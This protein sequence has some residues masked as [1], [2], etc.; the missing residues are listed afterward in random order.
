MN[1]T[2]QITNKVR[3][4][5]GNYPCVICGIDV[6]HVRDGLARLISVQNNNLT[7]WNTPI[8]PRY[9]ILKINIDI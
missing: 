7:L 3:K 1:Q 2:S 8:K 9:L 4:R 5:V 6:Q